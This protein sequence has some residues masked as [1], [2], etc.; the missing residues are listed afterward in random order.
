[1]NK[2][3]TIHVRLTQAEYL[4]LIRKAKVVEQVTISQYVHNLLFPSKY[5]ERDVSHGDTK[6]DPTSW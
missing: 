6:P 3:K 1:M 2:T 4:E 5:E